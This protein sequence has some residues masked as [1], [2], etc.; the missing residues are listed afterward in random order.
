MV[1]KG[2][3]MQ[4]RKYHIYTTEQC[5][6]LKKETLPSIRDLV[7]VEAFKERFIHAFSNLPNWT[8]VPSALTLIK[9]AIGLQAENNL[10][11]PDID[12]FLCGY[13]GQTLASEKVLTAIGE[14]IGLKFTV[15]VTEAEIQNRLEYLTEQAGGSDKPI[16][17]PLTDLPESPKQEEPSKELRLMKQE[18]PYRVILDESIIWEGEGNPKIDIT[19]SEK[20][21]GVYV[22]INGDIC[23]KGT[24]R[25]SIWVCKSY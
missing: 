23:W 20:G 24:K 5:N 8:P 12:N 16:V 19:K 9:R 22:I 4:Q 25:P 15:I 11:T 1:K 2:I 14:Y 21:R 17:E 13:L 6:W 18:K 10:F 3:C 7:K